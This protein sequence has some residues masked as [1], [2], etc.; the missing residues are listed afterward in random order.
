MG[1]ITNRDTGKPIA[2]AYVTI[3]STNYH[4]GTDSLGAFR[5]EQLPEGRYTVR[6]RAIGFIVDTE[7]VVIGPRTGGL[8]LHVPLVPQYLHRCWPG[9]Q[10]EGS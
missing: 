8:H 6:I 7:P 1:Q 5:I 10:D 9:R 4:A 3:D 2:G